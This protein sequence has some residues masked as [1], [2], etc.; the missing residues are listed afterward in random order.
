MARVSKLWRLN[1][2]VDPTAVRPTR[3]HIAEALYALQV[4]GPD[5]EPGLVEGLVDQISDSPLAGVLVAVVKHLAQQG[6]R[7][8]A[9]E[10]DGESF[11][12]DMPGGPSAGRPVIEDVGWVPGERASGPSGPGD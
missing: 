4:G 5:D 12:D 1:I 9:V 6:G 10:L 8:L 7:Y 2:V 3:A 11:L